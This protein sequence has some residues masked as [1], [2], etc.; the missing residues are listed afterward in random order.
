M[1]YEISELVKDLAKKRLPCV[2]LHYI[3]YIV[4]YILLKKVE[5]RKNEF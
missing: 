5:I 2:I 4:T 1:D 3:V